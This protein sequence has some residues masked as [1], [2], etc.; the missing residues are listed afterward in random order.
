M[1]TNC[2]CVAEIFVTQEHFVINVFVQKPTKPKKGGEICVSRE[3]FTFLQKPKAAME[4]TFL[5]TEI[6]S[7][8][9]NY[10]WKFLVIA[11]IERL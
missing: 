3:Y 8:P 7:P 2:D 10:F 9:N 4:I 1:K 11:I 5:T 6:Q